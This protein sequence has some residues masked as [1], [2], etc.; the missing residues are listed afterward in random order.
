MS[1][2]PGIDPARIGIWGVSLGGYYAARVASGD[3]RVR[4]CISLCGPY[5]FGATWDQL[6]ELS[7][8]AFRVRSQVGD[9]RAGQAARG[10]ADAWRAGPAS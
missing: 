2:L 5:S 10:R 6:P 3:R 4:A 7:R 1:A 8:E 9:R